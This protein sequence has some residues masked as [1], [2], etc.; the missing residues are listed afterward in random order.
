MKKRLLLILT[1][2]LLAVSAFFIQLWFWPHG[3][4][5]YEFGKRLE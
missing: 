5:G 1:V 4:F 3:Q 2:L